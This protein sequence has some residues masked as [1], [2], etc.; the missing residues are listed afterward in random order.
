MEILKYNTVDGIL[1]EKQFGEFE[2][3]V[4]VDFSSQKIVYPED[5]G[6]VVND[7]TT[8]N[9]EH[10]ENFVVFECINRLLMKGY[11]PEHLELEKRWTLV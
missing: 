1:Y 2:C 6:L 5:K 8:C 9:F 10:P 7:K 11:R 3:S 4:C